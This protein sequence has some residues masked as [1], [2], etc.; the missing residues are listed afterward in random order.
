MR[1]VDILLRPFLRLQ[2][3]LAIARDAKLRLLPLQTVSDAYVIIPTGAEP[4]GFE[5]GRP[6]PSTPNCPNCRLPFTR[7]LFLKESEIFPVQ[8]GLEFIY[9]WPCGISHEPFWYR[10]NAN[11][12]IELVK[13][14]KAERSTSFPFENYPDVFKETP[15]KLDSMDL[16]LQS[17]LERNLTGEFYLEYTEG[18]ID[19]DFYYEVTTPRTQIGGVPL[20]YDELPG[21]C[22]ECKKQMTFLATIGNKTLAGEEFVGEDYAQVVYEYCFDCH[23]VKVTQE[24]D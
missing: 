12:P 3:K 18:Q 24:C 8:G 1:I 2:F 9:C 10:N 21:F 22:L 7:F 6:S 4:D 23:L 16:K 5:G 14:R 20:R 13:Y 19:S 11:S 17:A 15:I